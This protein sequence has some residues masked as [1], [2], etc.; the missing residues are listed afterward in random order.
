MLRFFPAVLW[1]FVLICVGLLARKGVIDE[2]SAKT[3]LI[4]IPLVA[5][6]QLFGRRACRPCLGERQA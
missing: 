1:A 5:Y 6:M 3:L 2:G 4:V